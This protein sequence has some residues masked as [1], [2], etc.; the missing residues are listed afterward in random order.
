MLDKDFHDAYRKLNKAQREAVDTIEGPVMVVAGAGTG[1][2][3]ILALR[4]ANIL[5][6]TDVGA[7]GVLCLT[8]TN[9]G[10]RAMRERLSKYIGN[11]SNEVKVQTFHSFAQKIVEDNYALLDFDSMP[12]ILDG[13]ASV[14][15]IDEI[16]HRKDWKYIF[17]R[18]NPAKYFSDLKSTISL[19][20][21][22]NIGPEYLKK[23][24]DE[25]IEKLKKDP[26]SISSRGET[27]GE[28]KKDIQKKIESLEKTKE[29]SDF[30][31]LYEK[32]K[33]KQEFM[34][35]D[36]VLIH[37][38]GIINKSEDVSSSIREENQYILVDE[39]QDSSGI[40]NELL[41]AI[42]GK[43]E[44]P[45]IFV[46]GDDRQLIYGFGGAS[47]S[48]FEEFKHMFGKA[49]LISLT[50]NYRS[51]QIILDAAHV[52]LQS[53]MA[54]GI[55]HSNTIEN[56]DISLYECEYERDEILLAGALFKKKIEEGVDSSECALLVPKNKNV[57]SAVRILHD[58]NLPVSAG[59]NISFFEFDETQVFKS[60]L[61]VVSD[62]YDGVSIGELLF[63]PESK[64]HPL[65][66]HK[67]I[68]SIKT[69]D[70]CLEDLLSYE[71]LESNK[72]SLFSR[73]NQIKVFGKNIKR[74]IEFYSNGDIYSVVQLI[75]KEYFLDNA[76][77]HDH[78]VRSVEVARTYI[79]LATS[80]IEKY[81]HGKISDFIEYLDRLESY[82]HHIPLAV[83]SSN[84]GIQVMTLHASKG[85]EFEVV[86]IAHLNENSLMSGRH[87]AFTL[88][89]SIENIVKEKDELS[90]KRE[91]YVAITRAK[92]FCSLS[93]SIQSFTGANLEVANIIKE[94]PD[95]HI[96]KKALTDSI[97]IISG[98][99]ISSY[100][101][102]SS[103]KGFV[104]KSELAKIVSKEYT[105]ENVSVTAL[106]NFF[107]CP[108]KWYFNN[109]L[110]L[111]YPKTESLILGSVVHSSIEN[112]LKNKPRLNDKVVL[113]IINLSLDKEVVMDK[114][115]RARL[116]KNSSSILSNWIKN[117]YP[118][119]HKDYL[120][121]RSVSY[122]DKNMPHLKMYGKI[123][124]TER[125]EDGSLVVT[126]FKTGHSKTKNMIEKLDDDGKLSSYLRQLA[127][128]SY[129]LSGGKKDEKVSVSKLLF[130]EENSKDKN[131]VY[132]THIGKEEID[133]LL[134]DIK[135]YDNALSSSEWVNG[136]CNYKS[137]DGSEKECEFCKRAKIYDFDK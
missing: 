58:M 100:V 72:N 51:T 34:D 76:P 8:F 22:E 77:D 79:H 75:G 95:T 88:P 16:L 130:L 27:K 55:L 24:A 116:T 94:I 71:S 63:A 136:K 121:E 40:Q 47:V 20:K 124:F 35:Y 38:L 44:K 119:I 93:Y 3:Q 113:K 102:D 32:E 25:E 19:L 80:Y 98:D 114:A 45:N 101:V 129:L 36:D 67:F 11:A 131:A 112:I 106:N 15:L 83:I 65:T 125:L 4:I 68:R 84:S 30:Y 33:K 90:A 28:L 105:K 23:S 126:D 10:V 78:L 26:D 5:L 12:K 86:H 115:L 127:M 52:L 43:V 110:Q 13:E 132:A 109:F 21:R 135:E 85:L 62:P 54:D 57:R 46:V 87:K 134:E 81:P 9:S 120:T 7:S 48:F 96:H 103:T 29:V 59:K 99:N 70:L 42:W 41:R 91:L 89:E 73:A 60:L 18:G 61:K 133:L 107:E 104:D 69:R 66:A 31:S 118:H 123:D 111:P 97:K 53:K 37:A 64:I 74:W 122:M 14:L 1:K 82:N 56:H 39:H 17:S 50:E 49:H 137:H 2:T 128:Y 108:W 6:N 92:R 117:Y